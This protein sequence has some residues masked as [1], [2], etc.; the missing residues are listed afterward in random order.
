MFDNKYYAALGLGAIHEKALAGERLSFDD[1][2][3]L[4]ACPD[5]RA[6]GALAFNDRFRRHGRKT[7]YVVNR[8][9]NYTNICA[10]DCVFCAFRRDGEDEPGAFLLDHDSILARLRAAG[11]GALKLDEVHIVGG[12]HP[13]LPLSWFEELLRKIGENFPDLPIKGFTPVEIAHFARLEGVA[14]EDVLGRLRAAGLKMLPGGGA[15]IFNPELRRKLCPRK[16]TAEEWLAVSDAAHRQGIKSNCTMLF[17]HLETPEHRVEHLC[18]LREQQD[19]SGGFVSFIPLPFL[20]SNSRL[21]LPPERRGPIDGL[22]QLKTIAVSR[23][24]LDNIPHIKAY[25]IMLG[26]K[27]AQ[28]ALWHG[29]DDLDGTIVEEKIGHMAGA[30]DPQ[31]TTAAELEFMIRDAGFEPVRRDALFEAATEG[32]KQ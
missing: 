30:K 24:M 4:F 14:V 5:L 32:E 29:A 21:E 13:N 22:D 2:L 18:A 17:G 31:A 15:E 1:G 25:W 11:E 16:A 6:V 28:V 7:Y 9:I 19:R 26:V 20:K 27:L 3:K 23:L 8:Q 12:C 10:N